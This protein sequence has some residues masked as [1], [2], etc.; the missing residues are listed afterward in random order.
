MCWKA[1]S[2]VAGKG[3]VGIEIRIPALTVAAGALLLSLSTMVPGSSK[4]QTVEDLTVSDE[5]GT[6]SLDAK[7]MAASGSGARRERSG[8]K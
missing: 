4:P 5:L 6:V 2:E 3:E 8:A 1:M 7:N